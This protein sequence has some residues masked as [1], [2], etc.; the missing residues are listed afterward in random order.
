MKVRSFIGPVTAM[1]TASAPR[2][3]PVMA[4]TSSSWPPTTVSPWCW[5]RASGRRT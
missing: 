3:A 1:I 4:S 5:V 2:A